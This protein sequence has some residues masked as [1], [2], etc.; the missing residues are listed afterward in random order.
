MP[1]PAESQRFLYGRIHSLDDTDNNLKL[2]C[3]LK[4]DPLLVI[5]EREAKWKYFPRFPVLLDQEDEL[6]CFMLQFYDVPH[7]GIG[8]CIQWI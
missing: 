5:C 1:N 8:S 3:S 6:V 7:K 2:P 4:Q